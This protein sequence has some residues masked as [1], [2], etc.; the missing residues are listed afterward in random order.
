VF[1]RSALLIVLARA[2][3]VERPLRDGSTDPHYDAC[4][5][6]QI[7]RA[8]DIVIISLMPT[9]LGLHD[10]FDPHAIDL[11]PPIG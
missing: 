1:R 6:V 5:R 9:G 7:P 8:S 11:P 4:Y 2:L 3:V 10:A